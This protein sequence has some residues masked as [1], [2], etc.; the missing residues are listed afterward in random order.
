MKIAGLDIGTTGCKL[1]VFDEQGQD[2]GKAYRDYPAR[3]R[4]SGHEIDLSVVMDSVYAVIR[5]M[6]EK[7][8]DIMG[9]GVTSFGETFV[10]T[11]QQG[12]PL[13][14]AMLYTD[15]RGAEECASLAQKLGADRIAR[16]S[17]LAPHEMY[18]ISKIMW[19]KKHQPETYQQARH[20]FL[21]GDYVVWHLTGTAQIDYSLATR[22]MAFDIGKLTWSEEILEAAGIDVSLFS[23]PVPT[24]TAAG[25]VTKEAAEKTGL[26]PACRI[27]TVSHDQVAA[28]VGAGAFDGKTA[29][30]GA[31]TVE[32]LTPIYDHLPEIAVMSKGY[33]SVVPY[34]IPGKYV[35]YAFS[36]T[37]GALIQWCVN[38]FARAEQEEAKRQGISVNTLLE[39]QYDKPGPTGLLVLPHFAGAATP[40]MDTGSRGAIL[41]LTAGTSLPEIYRA[42]MEGVAYEMRL[43]YDAL[44]GSGIHFTKLHATGGGARSKVWMQMKADILNLPITSLKTSD[45]GTV[46]SAMLTGVASGVFSD[47]K[48]A[49]GIM[50]QRRETYH[51]DPR[52]HEQYMQVYER[53]RKVYHAVRPLV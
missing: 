52:R 7:Y 50:V 18:S 22:S 23:K 8:P 19:L 3:R 14:T 31:G 46:G 35:A 24:G 49:A 43:N 33:F 15:P 20:I 32:C 29:V 26:N 41:G 34:V 4:V 21:I 44:A 13:H 30:D 28:A 42:C 16:V 47:L 25:C 12:T 2:L 6:A 5:E 53:Y 37:G 9:I 27:V 11:D 45:A 1:T 38:T 40:Y 36:Y 48:E 51:P 10:M 17:G 39:Q